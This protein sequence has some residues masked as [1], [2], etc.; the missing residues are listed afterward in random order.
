MTVEILNSSGTVIDTLGPFEEAAGV[1]THEWQPAESGGSYKARI[2][3]TCT[4][5]GQPGELVRLSSG[6]VSKSLRGVAVDRNPDSPAYGTIYVANVKANRILAY[7]AD[8]T[9]KN[10]AAENAIGNS[11][12][13]TFSGSNSAPWGLGV[14]QLG[15]IYVANKALI[16]D[17]T[18]VKV[19]DHNGYE[20]HHIFTSEKQLIYWLEGISTSNGLE[21]CETIDKYVRIS[22]V[23]NPEWATIIGPFANLNCHQICFE[24]SG[25]ACYVACAGDTPAG[26]DVMRYVRVPGGTWLQDTSFNTGL[27]QFIGPS[28]IPASRFVTGVS[29]YSPEIGQ[30][31]TASGMLW[32]ALSCK[33]TSF[34]G[35]IVRLNLDSTSSGPAFLKGP[36][37]GNRIIAADAVGNIALDVG[38]T[39]VDDL[40]TTWGLYAVAGETNTD[41][42]TT[43]SV[44]IGQSE[45]VQI[46]S[47]I[48]DCHAAP[49]NTLVQFDSAKPVT[50]V[51]D[52][53][54]YI[55]EPD[56]TCGIK[57]ECE[58]S[59]EVGSLAKVKGTMSTNLGERVLVDAIL[60]Q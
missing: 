60:L 50:A 3:A 2:S 20:L 42:R 31:G 1:Q 19:F 14:D 11:L 12:P 53:C 32:V 35:N 6:T 24:A 9:A 58:S 10:W 40:W 8:G 15:N 33:N 4:Q 17:R 28:D 21:V 44:V 59:V 25:N 55:Q 18:G 36:N 23:A 39:S 26:P 37:P 5:D 49:D 7:Y 47:K 16:N 38:T 46:V 51:F 54:F 45:P 34:G 13:T 27:S 57:V 30:A 29:C 56:H 43:N 41:V 52:G 48:C 22:S